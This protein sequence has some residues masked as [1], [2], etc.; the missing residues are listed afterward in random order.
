MRRWSLF[1]ILSVF[2]SLSY[3]ANGSQIKL[4][5]SYLSSRLQQHTVSAIYRDTEHLLWIGTQQG[6]YQFD[7]SRLT[8]FNSDKNN[9]NWIPESE[10]VDIVENSLGDV[11][12]ATAPGNLLKWNRDSEEIT[13]I[14]DYKSPIDSKLVGISASKK[15]ASGFFI[16]MA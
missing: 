12:I 4:S 3:Q 15:A 5:S 2:C 10:V 11:F 14:L 9:K 13:N 6:L 8:L 7:G 1:L 16:E